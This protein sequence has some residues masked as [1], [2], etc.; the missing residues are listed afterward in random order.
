MK[1]KSADGSLPEPMICESKIHITYRALTIC[2]ALVLTS[3]IYFKFW[4]IKPM[5]LS[6]SITVDE[7]KAAGKNWPTN[8]LNY[9]M[10]DASSEVVA[11]FMVEAI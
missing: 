1:L 4:K 5:Y 8:E 9:L 2:I 6:S 3:A 10:S 11:D 7:D